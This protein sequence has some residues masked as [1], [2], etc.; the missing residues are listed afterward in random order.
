MLPVMVIGT[1][2]KMMANM[3]N[4]PKRVTATTIESNPPSHE[5][6]TTATIT[7]AG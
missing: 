1:M 2:M 4:A 6:A 5:Q 3:I 7:T